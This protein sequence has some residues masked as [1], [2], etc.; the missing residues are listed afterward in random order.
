MKNNKIIIVGA[1]FVGTTL[2]WCLSYHHK[3]EI[4]LIDK[5]QAGNGVTK[6]AFAWLN[7]SYGR[8]GA[9]SKLRQQ[10][11]NEWH[12]LDK[13]TNGK[14]NI[15]WSGAI[16]WQETES[17]T[18]EFI[19]IYSE[20]GFNVKALT[21]AELQT[22][23]PQLVTLPELAAFATEEGAV[24]PLH[25]TQ[26]L[27]QEAL[28]N[29]VT[30]LPET[31]VTAINYNGKQ[32][33]G[34][35]TSQGVICADQVV[36][37][38]GVGIISLMEKLGEQLPLSAS[39]SI[40]VLY[41]HQAETPFVHHIIST[42]DMEVR[43]IS[44]TALLAAEDYLNDCPEN[45]AT[46]IALNALPAI[47]KAFIGSDSLCLEKASVGM[48][49]IPKDEMPIVGKVTDYCGLYMISM[50]AAI[51]LAPLICRL[52][53]EEIINDTEQAALNPYRLTRFSAEDL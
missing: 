40:I 42:P 34:V 3:G 26:V 16:S 33:L 51:T 23:E 32:I 2:A 37:T 10:A 43:P 24:D 12:Y 49:P 7:V 14:L 9:Y 39:P 38:A 18:R 17:A 44:G 11:L 45:S 47:K 36:L 13:Q 27:L 52:A 35:T 50:H 22:L 15:N 20:S 41:Q 19:D 6:Q 53:Q 8:P 25:A 30:Y 4:I 28:N 29:G 5:G 1:G 46:C 21:K 48:R 31:E